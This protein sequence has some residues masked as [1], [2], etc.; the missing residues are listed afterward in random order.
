[1]AQPLFYIDGEGFRVQVTQLQREFE[2]RQ[3]SDPCTTLDGTCH[4]EPLGSFCH[5]L[6]TVAA[7]SD[8]GELERFWEKIC[9]PVESFLCSFP[10]GDGQL[11]QQMYV[12]SGSQKLLE[13]AQGNRWGSITLRFRG[14]TPR[15]TP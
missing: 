8:Q 7:W 11:T 13:A 6:M 4:R 5:Y 3:A 10:Y 9:Q 2:I 12:E 14:K 1:M 15:V